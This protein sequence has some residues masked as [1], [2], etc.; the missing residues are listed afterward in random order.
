MF[1]SHRITSSNYRIGGKT[2][3]SRF[4]QI[5]A[6]PIPIFP[7]PN[8]TLTPIRKLHGGNPKPQPIGGS[9]AEVPHSVPHQHLLLGLQ[10][11]PARAG[12][13]PRGPRSRH[14][15]QEPRLQPTSFGQLGSLPQQTANPRFVPKLHQTSQRECKI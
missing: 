12:R 11:R 9:E 7:L 2:T 8:Q 14:P 4:S 10:Q 15:P 3:H 13:G 6:S 1:V 5:S